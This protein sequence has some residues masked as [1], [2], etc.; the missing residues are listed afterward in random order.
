MLIGQLALKDAH[1]S[2]P[3]LG[4]AQ[5]IAERIYGRIDVAQ[6]IGKVPNLFRHQTLAA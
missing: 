6:V 3:E 1:V 2:A 5:R 4:V